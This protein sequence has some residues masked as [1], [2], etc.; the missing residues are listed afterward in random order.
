[1]GFDQLRAMIEDGRDLDELRAELARVSGDTW[2]DAYEEGAACKCHLSVAVGSVEYT[3]EDYGMD[4]DDALLACM[5]NL[6][7]KVRYRFVDHS[8]VKDDED[9]EEERVPSFDRRKYG[10]PSSGKGLY[11]WMK[12]MEEEF[13]MSLGG[14]LFQRKEIRDFGH[15]YPLDQWTIEQVKTGYDL[16]VRKMEKCGVKAFLTMPENERPIPE[17]EKARVAERTK[18]Y[19][20]LS[21][22]GVSVPPIDPEREKDRQDLITIAWEFLKARERAEANDYGTVVGWLTDLVHRLDLVNTSQPYGSFLLIDDKAT[23]DTI[24]SYLD[25]TKVRAEARD[26]GRKNVG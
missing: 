16:L 14:W 11:A 8:E 9:E 4:E 6:A 7:N 1:M 17:S 24:R 12:A 19:Q 26:R 22:F 18:A 2:A 5:T 3:T 21:M 10:C 15:R 13:A 23:L 25:K 20:E